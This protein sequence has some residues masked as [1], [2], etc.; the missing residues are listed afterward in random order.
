MA[1][2]L[3]GQLGGTAAAAG[4]AAD[5]A[6]ALLDG[7]SELRVT[8]LALTRLASEGIAIQAVEPAV[9]ISGADGAVVGVR[10]P[11]EYATGTIALTGEPGTGGARLRGGVVLVSADAR[12][13]ITGIR[14]S[15]PD[16]RVFA[17]LQVND[18]WVGELPLYTWDPAAVRLS[19]LPGAPGKPTVIKGSGIPVTAAQEGLDAFAEAF[20]ATL[21]APTDVVF[22]T[23]VEGN[24]WPLPY[25]PNS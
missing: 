7:L 25:P 9:P 17:F 13:E 19:V 15:V 1:A 3:L 5:P 8:D 20:G 23:S 16:N 22:T 4:S 14:G 12:M 10:M 21:F 18:E 2:P 11:P 6:F 24:A